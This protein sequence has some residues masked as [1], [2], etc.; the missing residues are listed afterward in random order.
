M[1]ANGFT[2]H[3]AVFAPCAGL[4]PTERW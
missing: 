2:A 3:A 1:E 4:G